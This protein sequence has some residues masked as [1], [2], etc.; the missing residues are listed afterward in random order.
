MLRRP[1]SNRPLKHLLM[2]RR[3]KER[4]KNGQSEL[5]RLS[6]HSGKPLRDPTLRCRKT[7]KKTSLILSSSVRRSAEMRKLNKKPETGLLLSFQYSYILRNTLNFRDIRIFLN[8][9]SVKIRTSRLKEIK[10]SKNCARSLVS[11]LQS[12]ISFKVKKNRRN[13]TKLPIVLAPL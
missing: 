12:S 4:R 9:F 5:R 11:I 10:T 6:A 13:G 3:L 2:Q 8:I 1:L 7:R